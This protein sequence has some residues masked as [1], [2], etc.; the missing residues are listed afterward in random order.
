MLSRYRQGRRAG[1]G[2]ARWV[3]GS[4]A[5]AVLLVAMAVASDAG[6]PGFA[7]PLQQPAAE[8]SRLPQRQF[9]AVSQ[10]GTRLVAVGQR[11]LIATSDDQGRSWQQRSVPVQVDLVAVDFVDKDHGWAS[12]HDGVILHSADAGQSWTRQFDGTRGAALQQWYA[13]WSGEGGAD[14]AQQ[15]ERNFGN[16]PWLPMLDVHFSTPAQGLALGSFGMLL[17]SSDGGAHWEPALHRIDNPEYLHL[18]AI[19]RSGEV[20]LIASERGTVFR[21]EGDGNF[22]PV[23]TG[24]SGSFFSLASN[25]AIVLAGGLRGV[26]YRSDDAGQSWAAVSTGL[27]Q[28]VSA[29]SYS[30][31]LGQF[32][33]VTV[34]GEA[35]LGDAE[36]RQFKPVASGKPGIYTGVIGLQDGLLISSMQGLITTSGVDQ[37]TGEAP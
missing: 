8:R 1:H 31:R 12:G 19:E 20:S 4:A 6:T 21:A 24:H 15:I 18:N 23:A 11:G 16:G 9:Q 25:G 3:V 14:Y 10:V 27:T 37:A 7:D 2:H 29:I 30:P 5:C 36:A 33:L 34:G 22:L 13:D 35:A 26:A 28:T 17:A 32:A